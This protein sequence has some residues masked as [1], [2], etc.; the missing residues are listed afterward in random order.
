[1]TPFI[2]SPNNI[3]SN[4][5]TEL[6]PNQYPLHARTL[7]ILAMKPAFQFQTDQIEEMKAFKATV[8]EEM[9]TLKHQ[10]TTL[11]AERERM[12][13][14]HAKIVVFHQKENARLRD[15]N[16][17]LELVRS[18]ERENRRLADDLKIFMAQS[19]QQKEIIKDL[20]INLSLQKA[21]LRHANESNDL[22]QKI[23]QEFEK[24]ATENTDEY[25]AKQISVLREFQA[26]RLQD[27]YQK[28]RRH[29]E[30]ERK[31]NDLLRRTLT[32]SQNAYV[33]EA[34][35]ADVAAL[36]EENL[37]LRKDNIAMRNIQFHQEKEILTLTESNQKQTIQDLD[38]KIHLLKAQISKMETREKEMRL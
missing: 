34:L 17:S 14:E 16:S 28:S 3:L 36:M 18:L 9:K 6:I 7:E 30:V 38:Q 25:D 24:R 11:A 35:K 1:M 37:K 29:L 13:D 27:L 4:S 10:L 26:H 19:E 23:I 32:E 8:F 22:K 5:N 33:V 20:E 31:Q 12:K 2:V 15:G 21:K